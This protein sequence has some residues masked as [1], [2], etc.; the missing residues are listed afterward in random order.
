MPLVTCPDC[1]NQV[2]D[3]APACPKCGG[4]IARQGQP[5]TMGT[6]LQVPPWLIISAEESLGAASGWIPTRH[7]RDGLRPGDMAKVPIRLHTP[8]SDRDFLEL[9]WVEILTRNAP[10]YTGRLVTQPNH[11]AALSVGVEVAF[12]SEHILD[13]RRSGVKRTAKE[14]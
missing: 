9:L 13:F 7:E 10:G 2:S 11:P 1:G 14:I 5:G 4:P 12:S 8:S 6:P 3:R